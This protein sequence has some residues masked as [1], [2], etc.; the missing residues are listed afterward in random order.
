MS[1]LEEISNAF[2]A[3]ADTFEPVV[4]DLT[5]VDVKHIRCTIVELLQS[6]HYHGNH[7]SLSGL[8]NLEAKYTSHFFHAFVRLED[9]DANDYNPNIP[10]T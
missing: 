8:I 9:I 3:A 6:F 10:L 5:D 2:A 4:G 1:T 7:D